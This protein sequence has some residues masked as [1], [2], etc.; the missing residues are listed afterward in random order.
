MSMIRCEKIVKSFGKGNGK[1]IAVQGIS[2]TFQ[3]GVFYSVIGR[4]GSG[5][6]TLLHLLSGITQPDSGSIY[7]D[8]VE[9]N[10]LGKKE[11]NQ[12]RRTRTGFVFQDYQLLPE[13]TVFE[14]MILPLVLND[15]PIDEAWCNRILHQLEIEDISHRYPDEI[16]GGQ[17]QRTAIGR[18]IVH[19]PSFIFA[20][21]PT[22]NLDKKTSESVLKLLVDIRALY[23][24]M[25][26]LVTHDLDIARSADKLL[27]IEDGR[28]VT[29]DRG[30]LR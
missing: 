1:T 9:I 6:S 4:S 3:T 30:V 12:I 10:T 5:K 25:I 28:F 16:S 23:D 17:Q 18:A 27:H 2:E 8:D 13:L 24:P 21:E 11:Q 14:N 26:L 22:G 15:S 20:D 19:K 7:Y 29:A